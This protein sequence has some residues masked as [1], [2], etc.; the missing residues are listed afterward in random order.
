MINRAPRTN[1]ARGVL[2]SF[3]TFL[4]SSARVVTASPP[5]P[6]DLQSIATTSAHRP[7]MLYPASPS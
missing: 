6:V 4:D 5:L 1:R 3:L 2:P 7:E